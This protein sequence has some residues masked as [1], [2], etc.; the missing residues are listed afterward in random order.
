M[1]LK[2]ILILDNTIYKTHQMYDE[3][4]IKCNLID[5][6][7]INKLLEDLKT[8]VNQKQFYK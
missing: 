7:A 6:N 4:Y 1:F 2:D 5:D 3:R 8:S